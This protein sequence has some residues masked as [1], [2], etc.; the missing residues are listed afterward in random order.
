[1]VRLCEPVLDAIRFT[2]NV[3]VPRPGDDRSPVLRLL[4]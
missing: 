3:A 2:D 4:C 1:M